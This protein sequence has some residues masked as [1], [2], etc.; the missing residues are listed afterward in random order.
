MLKEE[1]FQIREPELMSLRGAAVGI[2]RVKIPK[3]SYFNFEIPLLSFIVIKKEGGGFV[4]V[5]IHMQIDGYGATVDEAKED[6]VT[7]ISC[8][9]CENF[10]NEKFSKC[11]WLNLLDL[12]KSNERSSILWDKYHAVQLRLAERGVTTDRYTELRKRIKVLENRVKTLEEKA[13]KNRKDMHM[14]YMMSN[15]GYRNMIVE[16]EDKDEKAVA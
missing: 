3:T 4:S 8:Y 12:F 16:Y 9:L 2:G 7:N 5:C 10:G 14:F 13:R 6:M 15:L 11:C 1:D